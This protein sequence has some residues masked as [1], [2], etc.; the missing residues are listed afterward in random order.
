MKV[1]IC[2]GRDFSDFVGLSRTLDIL[3]QT[4]PITGVVQG[5]ARGADSLAERWAIQRGVPCVRVPAEWHTHGR[6]AG[7]MRNQKMIDKHAPDA[8]VAFLGGAGTAD[9]VR[10]AERAGLRVIR[11]SEL[12]SQ[13]D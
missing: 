7:P 13:L 1:I 4:I 6:R 3:R 10:R 11:A 5:G 9:M 2:G 12:D 8:V